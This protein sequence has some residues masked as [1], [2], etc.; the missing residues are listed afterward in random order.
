MFITVHDI[1]IDRDIVVN[2]DHIVYMRPDY[3]VCTE[4]CTRLVM[5]GGKKETLYV[6]ES[7]SKIKSQI[8]GFVQR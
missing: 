6:S 2:S 7:M 1:E 8:M 4:K 5:D 3:Y